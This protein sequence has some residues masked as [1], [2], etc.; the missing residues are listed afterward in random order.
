MI[1]WLLG[2]ES[3]RYSDLALSIELTEMALGFAKWPVAWII[4][5]WI[6]DLTGG[7]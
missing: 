1:R 2:P 6:L 3:K 4:A 7:W 5:L